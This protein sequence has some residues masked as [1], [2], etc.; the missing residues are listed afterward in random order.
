[1]L[2]TLLMRRRRDERGAAMLMAIAFLLFASLIVTAI[3]VT[4]KTS[5]D[6]SRERL[7]ESASLQLAR[8]AGTALSNAYSGVTSGEFDGFAPTRQV[9]DQHARSIG[10]TLVDNGSLPSGLSTVDNGRVPAGAR[11]TVTRPLEDGRIGYWQLFSI[12]M[13][14]WG[15]TR[16]GRVVV[17]VRVW[18]SPETNRSQVSQP[19]LYRLEFRPTWF[20]DFQMLFDGHLSSGAGS[21]LNGRVHSNGYRTSYFDV[22]RTRTDQSNFIHMD[23][24]ASCAGAARLSVATQPGDPRAGNA[25]N[26]P[27]ACPGQYTATP[28]ARY[29]LLRSRDLVARLRAICTAGAPGI[30]TY[31]Q[32]ATVPSTNV[33]L[34]GTTVSVDGRSLNARV[35][36]DVPG[37]NQGAV[38][39]VAGNVRLS[40][41]LSDG[42]R[43]MVVAASLPNQADYGQGGAPAVWMG[44][45]T[46]GASGSNAGTSSV[47]VV[48]EGDII[49]DETGGSCGTTFIGAMVSMSGMLSSH[50][51]Y[52]VP[53]VTG[54]RTAMCPNAAR[55]QGSVASHFAPLLSQPANNGGFMSRSI[56]WDKALYD[57]PPPLFP[58]AADWEATSMQPAN[59]DCF[60]AGNALNVLRTDC[61]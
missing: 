45:G 55:V 13:P 56:T 11:S 25:L 10:G 33:V 54:G 46:I 21:V 49:F 40:G 23:A 34:S 7:D 42:A 2:T 43:A 53:F 38:V 8:D 1:M 57:N 14:K 41:R 4:G 44:A 51:T 61:V 15:T 3:V 6:T 50:P 31:C 37:S 48:A 27:G 58:T 39:V 28:G 19:M 20:A 16:A 12:K 5:M 59:L 32:T 17:Y 35:A 30:S 60:G 52:R 26:G 29:N 22:Y 36:G 18:T 24:G 47:G 9:L